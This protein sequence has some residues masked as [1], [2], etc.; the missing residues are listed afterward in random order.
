MRRLPALVLVAALPCA[1]AYATSESFSG[2]WCALSLD[3]GDPVA[4]VDYQF[5]ALTGVV[6]L[7]RAGNWRIAYL[8]RADSEDPGATLVDARGVLS[9]AGGAAAPVFVEI[10]GKALMGSVDLD[11]LTSSG[12]RSRPTSPARSAG[13]SAAT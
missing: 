2:G 4:G 1:A 6:T 10:Q 13:P 7:K 3:A 11:A 5:N 9:A 12:P 8:D